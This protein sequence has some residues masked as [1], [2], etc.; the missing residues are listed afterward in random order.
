VSGSCFKYYSIK[1]NFR[2]KN[3]FYFDVYLVNSCNLLSLQVGRIVTDK[4]IMSSFYAPFQLYEPGGLDRVL[5]RLLHAP[6]Q[7]E[8]EFINEVMTNHMFQNSNE[9]IEVISTENEV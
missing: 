2:V 8:D 9:G 1:H 7:K 5:Q 3:N 4:S 6:A